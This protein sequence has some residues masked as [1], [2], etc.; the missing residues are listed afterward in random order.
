MK[1]KNL[2]ISVAAVASLT[3]C[4][5]DSNVM[6]GAAIPTFTGTIA[7]QTATR[8]AGTAWDNGDAIGITGSSVDGA[9]SAT[10]VKYTTANGDGAFSPAEG[11]NPITFGSTQKA[12]FSAYYPYAANGGT[13]TVSTAAANQTA[14]NQ[15][16][17]D[18]LYAG[19]ATANIVRPEVKF[20]F[21][22]VMSQLV[23][24]IKAGTGVTDLSKLTK[25]E[26]GDL[27]LSGTFNTATGAT[28]ATG[29][30]SSMEFAT[31][32]ASG[33]TSYEESLILLP[34]SV[35]DSKLSLTLT[36]NNMEYSASLTLADGLVSGYSTT[37][38]V[39]LNKTSVNVSDGS[40]NPWNS[41]S[42]TAE[43]TELNYFVTA[44]KAELYALA[45]TDG[46]YLNVWNSSRGAID[47]NMWSIYEKSTS[48]KTPCGVVYWLSTE[49]LTPL[50]NDNL[51]ASEHP[52]CTHG[53][54]V[55]LQ[56][57][58]IGDDGTPVKS[59]WQNQ[60]TDEYS[61]SEKIDEMET[62]SKPSNY[63][64]TYIAQDESNADKNSDNLAKLNVALGYNNTRLLRIYNK[65][66]C[67]GDNEQYKVIPIEKL[68]LF[69]ADN[70]AP[71]E[72]SGWYLPSPRELVWLVKSD[73]STF[74]DGKTGN[75]YSTSHVQNVG[76]VI[77]KLSSG[78][79]GLSEWY[80][81]SSEY[82]QMVIEWGSS[83]YRI[84]WWAAWYVGFFAQYYGNVG[85]NGKTSEHEIRAVCA[86]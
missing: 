20:Q 78:G 31:T 29:N 77:E 53:Y 46:T 59:K 17:I 72:S 56:D 7:G 61:V 45:F 52:E 75:H 67:V 37:Y 24:N 70:E 32:I 54:I 12:T 73:A 49:E 55:A 26:L 25:I 50:T 34:Q 42:L 60:Q 44:D 5:N 58:E 4:S 74:N 6:D 41:S 19:G 63:E 81:S 65:E 62:K 30:A 79:R 69:A 23:L 76:K 84:S 15:K 82:K 11:V 18:F 66:Y 85:T 71:D 40:I 27:K 86:F 8:M 16:T 35:A 39:T 36:Y 1:L 33:T 21:N 28:L 51:L 9:T 57:V 68:D 13:V 43:A 38:N 3:A 47:S 22:H 48:Y 64:T 14:T 80:W 2:L 83:D 10:N